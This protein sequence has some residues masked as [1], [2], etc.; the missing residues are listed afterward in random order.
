VTPPGDWAIRATGLGLRFFIRHHHPTVHSRLAQLMKRRPRADEFWALRDVSFE[1]AAGEVLGV[2]GPNGSGK[3]TLLRILARILQPDEGEV[4]LRG[5]V[6]SLISLG[7]GF[8]IQLT[9]RENIETNGLLLGLTQKQVAERREAIIEFADL[10]AFIDAPVRTYSTGMRA[11]LGFSVAV[12]VDPEILVVDEVLVVGDAAFRQRCATKIRELLRA[13]T[14]VVM[15]Q[16]DM[17]AII[18]LCH[19]AMWLER[20]RVQ[21][22]GDP[23]DIVN[24]YLG[25][26]GLA[27]IEAPAEEFPADVSQL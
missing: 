8:H 18:E 3:S 2:I 12:H 7:A 20:G 27:P 6:S 17:H 5:R 25:S 13:G 24:A 1:V 15:V 14:T 23:R 16:H 11:R 21:Q 19:R 22:I 9:G 4:A 10:G 26:R